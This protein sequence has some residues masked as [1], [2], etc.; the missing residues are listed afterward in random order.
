VDRALCVRVLSVV[1]GVV[2]YGA[3]FALVSGLLGATTGVLG[4]VT[5]VIAPFLYAVL[6]V[7]IAGTLSLPFQKSI[8]PGKFVRDL[9]NPLYA[10]RRLYGVCWSSVYYCKPVYAICL[11]VPTLRTGMFRLFGYR[12]QS[13]FTIYPDTWIRDLPLLDFGK[14]AYLANR[15]TLGSNIVLGS[16]RIFVGRII[17]EA[18]AVVGHLAKIGPR[19]VIGEGA[20]AG[21]GCCL[22]VGVRMG[23]GSVVKA[24][25][26]LNHYS[27]IGTGSSIGEGGYVGMGGSVADSIQ[28]PPGY[29]VQ[30][31]AVIQ[32]QPRLAAA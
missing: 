8:T 9:N 28:L 20:E 16:G 10:A 1:F 26:G 27:Q 12:G 13:D 15:A 7:A 4:S 25:G 14:G 11:A 19:C 30:D 29:V 17:V 22:G 6:F 23:A 32:L 3:P 18:N 21:V 31:D 24:H 2:I 5:L